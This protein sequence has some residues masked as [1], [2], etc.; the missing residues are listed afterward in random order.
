MERDGVYRDH[1]APYAKGETWGKAPAVVSL[2]EKSGWAEKRKITKSEAPSEAQCSGHSG[3]A[4]IASG[5][6]RYEEHLRGSP[7]N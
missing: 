5:P 6:Q 3:G 4:Y 7:K 1:D 2:L